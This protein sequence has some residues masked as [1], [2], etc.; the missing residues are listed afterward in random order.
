M[1]SA[2]PKVLHPLAGRPIIE[3]VL[4]TVDRARGR[5]RPCSSSATAATTFAPRSP[6][7]GRRSSSSCSRRS[8]GR[9]TRCCKPS[10]SWPAS[11]ARVLLL[12]GDVPLLEAGTLQRLLEQHRA[13]PRVCDRP[14][15][16]ARRSVRLRTHRA[17]RR[18]PDPPD[19]GRAR[20]VG[21]RA[22]DSR[23]Q[24]R[25]LRVRS[26]AAVS[27]A[28]RTRDRQRAGRVLPDRSGRRSTVGR[29][30]RSRRSASTRPPSC[31]ASTAA[32]ISPSSASIVRARKQP[33]P[34]ARRRDARRSR[35]DLRRR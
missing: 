18:R 4:R 26:G 35:R 21:R 31:A 29:A 16:G 25:D 30:A 9:V 28:A 11:P 14:H 22:R 13:D 32:S 5:H 24:Q 8:S 12:Y 3:H 23:D 20:R 19:R 6:I 33:R 34:D 15:R 27:S 1:K 10:R 7:G 2:L 17:R